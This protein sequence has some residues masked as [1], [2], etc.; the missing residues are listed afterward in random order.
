MSISDDGI[1]GGTRL[2]NG[3]ATTGDAGAIFDPLDPN[4]EVDGQ[5]LII[6]SRFVIPTD[7]SELAFPVPVFTLNPVIEDIQPRSGAPGTPVVILGRNFTPFEGVVR[8][9]G[10]VSDY[11]CNSTTRIDSKVPPAASTGRVSVDGFD[12]PFDFVV[13]APGTAPTIQSFAPTAGRAGEGIN[14]TGTNLDKVTEVRFNG[15]RSDGIF[16]F[17]PAIL[18]ATVPQGATT[19]PISV[20][21]PTGSATSAG[22]FTV[23]TGFPSITSFSPTAGAPGAQVDIFGTELGTANR[24]T[25]NAADAQFTV[26]GNTQVR[27]FVPGFVGSGPIRVHTPLGIAVSATNFFAG[28]GLPVLTSFT[29]TSGRPNDIVTL[30]GQNL[31]LATGVRIGALRIGVISRPSNQQ[32]TF[33]VPPNAVTGPIILE[34]AAGEVQGGVF[35]VLPPLTTTVTGIS[36]TQ[37]FPGIGVFISGTALDRVTGGSFAPGIPVQV[38]PTGDGRLAT[39]VP[40]G[41]V[42]GPITLNTPTGPVFTPVFTVIPTDLPPNVIVLSPGAGQTFNAGQVIN[43]VWSAGDDGTIVSQDIRYS[44]TGGATFTTLVPGLPGATRDLLVQLPGQGTDSAVIAVRAT[45]NTGKTGEGRSGT[46]RVL[47]APMDA[48]PVVA[49]TTPNGGE[50]LTVGQQVTIS[51]TSS[52]DKGLVS[53]DVRFSVDGGATFQP[54]VLGIPGF[55]QN[56]MWT[57]PDLPTDRALVSVTATDTIG[58]ATE[59]RSNAFFRIVRAADAKPLVTVTTPNGGEQLTAGQTVTISWTSSDDKGLVSHD[60]R[61]SVDGGATFQPVVLGI[62]GTRQNAMWTVPDL[63]TDRA[64]VSVTATDTIGQTTEDRSNAF[65]TIAGID[66]PPTVSVLSPNGGEQ[67]LAG[68]VARISWNS[69]DDRGLASHDVRFS[70]NGGQTFQDIALGLPGSARETFWAVPDQPTATALVMVTARD[71]AGQTAEDRSNAF[72]RI[73]TLVVAPQVQ[74]VAPM[75][76]PLAGGTSV[77]VTGSAFKPGCRVRF[78]GVDAATTFI[79]GGRLGAVTP[80]GAA[81]GLVQ[82]SVV[83]PDGGSGGLND[84]FRYLPPSGEPVSGRLV[85]Q[86]VTVVDP[87]GDPDAGVPDEDGF[88]PT[89]GPALLAAS[90]SS[91]GSAEAAEALPLGVE[92]ISLA[93]ASA[94]AAPRELAEGGSAT[95]ISR[96]LGLTDATLSALSAVGGMVLVPATALAD[97]PPVPRIRAGEVARFAF[98]AELFDADGRPVFGRE[99][100]IVTGGAPPNST[101]TVEPEFVPSFGTFVATLTTTIDTPRSRYRLSF[102]GGTV[103]QPTLLTPIFFQDIDVDLPLRKVRVFVTPPRQETA[104]GGSATFDIMLRRKNI[105]GVPVRPQVR[106]ALPPGVTVTFD[107]VRITDRM[108]RMTVQT[109][110]DIGPGDIKVVVTAKVNLEGTRAIPADPVFVAV[111]AAPAPAIGRLEIGQVTVTDPEPELGEIEPAVEPILIAVPAGGTVAFPVLALLFDGTGA[112]VDDDV[113][114]R[115]EGVPP[116]AVAAIIPNPGRT[117]VPSVVTVATTR[118]TPVGRYTLKITGDSLGITGLTYGPIEV[119]L[120]VKPRIRRVQIVAKTVEVRVAPGQTAAFDL[121]LERTGFNNKPLQLLVDP[122]T[123]PAGSTAAFEPAAPTGGTAVLRIA[124]TDTTPAG[125]YT[126]SIGGKTDVEGV[127]VRGTTV[128]LIVDAAPAARTV[129]LAVT[130]TTAVLRPGLAAKFAVKL[131]RTNAVDVVVALRAQGNLPVGTTFAFTPTRTTTGASTLVVTPPLTARPGAYTFQVLGTTATPDVTIEPSS[132]VAVTVALATA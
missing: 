7:G 73:S 96:P 35:T 105:P 94:A 15:V 49:V 21:G 27:A 100:R 68:Q 99:L 97:P 58:Q 106:N 12:S 59:D 90:E 132:P 31:N 125:T 78:G 70:A 45:D 107:P 77:T 117:F 46:F 126:V 54:V 37:G 43:V 4:G 20:S 13:L 57:V 53:H 76:G 11:F 1:P 109:P 61:F 83:N 9:N 47:G 55:R 36:P 129:K 51:W 48:R 71:T 33:T 67:L 52:D 26:V 75:E 80:R 95:A 40:T 28:S 18:Q 86:S 63:P 82:V 101:L 32:I 56:A 41:A 92:T 23:A 50:Q 88:D 24:V 38:N 118:L 110:P 66:R 39:T 2:L 6:G 14:I 102:Q 113:Q 130:P 17:S 85:L 5:S 93:L 25:F 122:A 79:D 89:A 30:N 69:S 108:G 84:A 10:A 72:F 29:P 42:T 16:A 104:P 19:G 112:R 116:G 22:S 111:K 87:A 64:L 124:T 115:I 123:L 114:F 127:E 3:D 128:R 8:F 121:A 81:A 60:V 44:S 119:P 62:P 91:A 74:M 98:T 120:E 103:L 34:S 131:T 65:F